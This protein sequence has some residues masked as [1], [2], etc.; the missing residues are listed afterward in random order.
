MFKYNIAGHCPKCGFPIFIKN[1]VMETGENPRSPSPEDI[2]YLCPCIKNIHN[3]E[4][5]F[6]NMDCK[7]GE[8][9]IPLRTLSCPHCGGKIKH[10]SN[11]SY[12]EL[13]RL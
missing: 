2:V 10:D 7:P 12:E 9:M 1:Y 8:I 5:A 13:R 4:K 6:E 11:C 3:R